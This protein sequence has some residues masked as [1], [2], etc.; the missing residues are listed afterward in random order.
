V[1]VLMSDAGLVLMCVVVVRG[2]QGPG[3]INR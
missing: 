2:L 3:K 1:L